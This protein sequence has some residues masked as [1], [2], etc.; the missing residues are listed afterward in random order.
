MHFR[1][2]TLH[3]ILAQQPNND[4]D[5]TELLLYSGAFVV[6]IIILFA[7]FMAVRSYYARSDSAA[8]STPFTLA[9]L[10][11]LHQTGQ[12]TDEQFEK[13]KEAMIGK[14]RIAM[15][16]SPPKPKSGPAR[17]PF[18]DT[19]G[20]GQNPQYSPHKPTPPDSRPR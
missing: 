16:D 4:R 5:L 12:L 19:D 7:L 20:A 15:Q 10:R 8:A 14:A 11:K 6:G 18:H 13:A 3:T 9:E 17:P 2:P 1:H